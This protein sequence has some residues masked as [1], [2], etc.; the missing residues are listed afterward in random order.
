MA[1]DP[2][3]AP[4]ATAEESIV[5]AL[6]DLHLEDYERH[7]RAR[8]LLGRLGF[9]D[10]EVR[11]ATLSGGWKKRLAIARELA[12]EP[13]ILLLDE[14]TNHLDLDGILELEKALLAETRAFVVASHDRW[15]LENVARRMLELDRAY[16]GGLLA[17]EGRYSDLL[18]KRDEVRRNQAD[19]DET[20][21]NRAR[22]ELEWLRRG[23]KARTTKS[24][25]RID[26][27]R[28]LFDELAE[29]RTRTAEGATAGIE[30]AATGRKTKR[31]LVATR[32]RQVV[33]RPR[34]APRR[35]SP[36][37]ARHPA[38]RARR[39][40]QRQDDAPARCSPARSSP[41]PARSSARRACARVLFEQGRESLDPTLTLRRALA[42]EGG[43]GRP[44]GSRG[45]RR[46]PGRSAS[47]SAPSSSRAPV[48]QPLGRRAGAHPHRAAHARSRPTC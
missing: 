19:Y 13:D 5:A 42:P 7:G 20:L 24:K 41:T 3:L 9:D 40:R 33:R 10:P 11:V 37:G 35:R 44:P 2:E 1:Q 47:S 15:F 21:A 12:R 48:A 14:P 36:A 43:L 26:G 28:R 29:V 6:A 4:G 31:L 38:R 34:R 46:R 30:F 23:P 39:Q 45:P 18:E 27:A 8:R 25:A 17:V 16:P 22:R 32:P